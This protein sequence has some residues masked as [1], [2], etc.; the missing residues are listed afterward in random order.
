MPSRRNIVVILCDQLRPD[1]LSVYGG[2]AIPTPHLD[3][4]AARGVVFD[5]AITQSTV[6]APSR[7][8]MMTGRYVSD[9]GV[10]T[11]DVPFRDGLEYLP[12]RINARGYRTGCFGKLHHFPADDAKG[13]QVYHPMEEGRL[14]EQEPYLQWLRERHPEAKLWNYHDHTFD[15]EDDEYHEHWIADRAIDFVNE[16]TEPFLAWVSFQGPHAPFDP[17]KGV[18]GSCRADLMPRPLERLSDCPLPDIPAYRAVREPQGGDEGVM[19]Q[20]VAYGEMIVCIDQQ[21]GRIVEALAAKGVLGDTTILFTADHGD[22]LGDFGLTAKG[23]FPYRGQLNVPMIIA[24]HPGAEPGT[25]SDRLVGTIDIA[26]TCLDIVGDERP[27]GYSRSMLNPDVPPREVNYCE[28]CDSTRVV[29]D[30]RYRYCCYPFT[31]QAELYDKLQDPDER[32]NLSGWPEH[33]ETELRLLRHALEFQILA[34]GPRIEAHD[35][36]PSQQAGLTAKDPDWAADFPIAFPL[37]A[38]EVDRLAEAGLSTTF[39][40][41]C[42]GRNV[43]RCYAKPYWE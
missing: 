11:N 15:Y 37:N 42:R 5:Q 7:A 14:G 18:K 23:P 35:C 16:T 40:E 34:K 31:G 12:E 27:L 19:R 1:F 25:R 29:D 36:V 3:A 10:W 30:G 9:H 38:R 32:L 26:G 43:L 13:F 24:G 41:F 20:R 28:F 17:P 21:L 6:C 2:R 8:T 22:L 33:A 39:N 4:L